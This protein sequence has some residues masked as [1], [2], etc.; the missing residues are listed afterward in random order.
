MTARLLS[1]STPL[2]GTS[3]TFHVRKADGKTTTATAT[4]DATGQA[5]Y[6]LRLR[7]KDP[8]GTW[9]VTASTSAASSGTA[10]FTVA[11]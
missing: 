4:S 6:R 11:K 5:I 9:Q 7:A 3:V 10:T 8:V 2:S 1:G